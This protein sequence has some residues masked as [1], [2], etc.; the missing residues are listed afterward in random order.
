MI[1]NYKHKKLQIGLVSP[2]QIRASAK[3]VLSNFIIKSMNQKKMYC[4]VKE[5][6][7]HKKQNLC[8]WKFSA[9]VADNKD[10][11]FCKKCGVEFVSLNK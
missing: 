4:F 10:E 9:S 11:N 7:D 2:Q 6:L 5:S 3:K 1:D 8:L